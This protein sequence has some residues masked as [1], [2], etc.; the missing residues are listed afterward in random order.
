MAMNS[1]KGGGQGGSDP[2]MDSIFIFL[3]AG[4]TI[5]LSLWMLWK[6]NHE[7][8]LQGLFISVGT[9]SKGLQHIPW[10]FPDRY[11]NNFL[12]WGNTLHLADP[13]RFGW[14]AAKQMVGVITYTLSIIFIPLVLLR[15]RLLKRTHIIKK[16]VRTFNLDKLKSTNASRYAAVASVQHENLLNIPVH[17]GPMATARSPIDFALEN[18]LVVVTRSGVGGESLRSLFGMEKKDSK[19]EKLKPIKGWTSKKM[20]WSVA[21]RRRVM[22][23]PEKC[24]LDTK[25]TDSLLAKQ[26]GGHFNVQSLD[27]FER[28]ALAVLLTAKAGNLADARTLSL[29]LA[30][31]YKR[32]N[33]KG[34]HAPI[35]DD[36][37]VDDI[38]KKLI[39]KPAI[40][41]ITSKHAFKVTV[42][43]GLFE[44][45]WKKGIFTIG[46]ILWIKGVHRTLFMT[47]ACLGGDRPFAEALGPWG[48]YML[49]Q[50]KK[51]AIKTPCIEAGT[52]ALQV[53]LFD[54]EWIGSEDG[55]A[56]EI[57]ARK[58]ILGGND[59][60]HSPTKGID[61]FDPPPRP[62]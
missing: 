23:Y 22:P 51:M 38:I 17:E 4:G 49:E 53:M 16:Y 42:F 3:V 45:S 21:E 54:E 13:G 36:R 29:R 10:I 58:A 2:Q 52:D 57:A 9:L 37:G 46:E 15:I 44:G 24:R 18:E 61:L 27:K 11:A 47:L 55:L 33:S 12:N 26:L 40:R 6:A 25:K 1:A 7:I 14:P 30:R 34:K 60:E 31:S 20:R 50:Q 39:N 5:F 62:S 28:C 19:T 56:S 35:I 8:I 32:L 41:D 59:D 48:H 43:M